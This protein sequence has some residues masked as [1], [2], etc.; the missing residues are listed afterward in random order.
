MPRITL[1]YFFVQYL[2][3]LMCAI[4]LFAAHYVLLKFCC[5]VAHY[6][7]CVVLMLLTAHMR[8][9]KVAYCALY[10][11][12]ILWQCCSL[13]IKRTFHM[14]LTHLLMFS[15]NVAQCSVSVAHV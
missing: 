9:R 14:L 10:V 3:L 7:S 2:H 8:C 1:W 13:F 11:A 5:N 6:S 15:C 12:P 4:T